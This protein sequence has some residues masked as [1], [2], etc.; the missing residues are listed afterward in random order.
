MLLRLRRSLLCL[1]C[2]LLCRLRGLLRRLVLR[3][4]CRGGCAPRPGRLRLLLAAALLSRLKLFDALLQLLNLLLQIIQRLRTRR[5][6]KHR[7]D[8]NNA[9]ARAQEC[10]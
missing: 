8:R 4:G 7:R 1:R 3:Q 9:G 6:G 10:S 2:R 5:S